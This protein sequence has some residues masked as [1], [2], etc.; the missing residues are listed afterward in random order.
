M[1][2]SVSFTH[3]PEVAP[4]TETDFSY[5]LGGVYGYY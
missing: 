5:Q 1:C 3:V 4:G 2:F